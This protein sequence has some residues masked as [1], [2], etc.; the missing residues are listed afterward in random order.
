MSHAIVR[1][2]KFV[3]L[4]GRHAGLVCELALVAS[5]NMLDG[6]GRHVFKWSAGSVSD[7]I[8]VARALAT[9]DVAVGHMRSSRAGVLTKGIRRPA[10][11]QGWLTGE[12]SVAVE[13][14]VRSLDA[15]EIEVHRASDVAALCAQLEFAV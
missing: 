5:S 9:D 15:K 8:A 2:F 14:L 7:S 4:S 6:K 3:S 11:P 12:E 10:V 13:L 1:E